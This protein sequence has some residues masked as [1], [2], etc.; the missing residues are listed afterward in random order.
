M[1]VAPK[2]MSRVPTM[3]GPMPPP[4]LVV[5][6]GRSLVNQFMSMTDRPLDTT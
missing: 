4:G 6:A 3:A 2:V 5:T 1:T